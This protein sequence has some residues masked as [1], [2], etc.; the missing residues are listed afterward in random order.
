MASHADVEEF[1]GELTAM[2]KAQK[3][4]L[5]PDMDRMEDIGQERI[6]PEERED[7]ST[8]TNSLMHPRRFLHEIAL[9]IPQGS[10]MTTDVGNNCSMS[11]DYFHF[12]GV[13]QLLAALSWGSCGFA[14]GGC[15]RG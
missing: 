14:M 13:P 15:V 10:I 7:W 3:P 9:V 2:V 4:D 6:W 1:T 12:K 11:N 5:R 8:S